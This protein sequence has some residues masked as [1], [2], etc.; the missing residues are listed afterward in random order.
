MCFF[1]LNNIYG[2]LSVSKRRKAVEKAKALGILK[3]R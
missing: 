1:H 3:R 2:K